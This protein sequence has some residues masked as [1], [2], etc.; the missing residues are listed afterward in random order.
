MRLGQM[1]WMKV[2]SMGSGKNCVNK[3]NVNEKKLA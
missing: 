3:N 1:Q 2:F